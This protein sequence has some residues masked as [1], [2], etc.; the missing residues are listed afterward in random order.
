M[1]WSMSIRG[2]VLRRGVGGGSVGGGDE[3]FCEGL[4]MRKA[5]RGYR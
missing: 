4:V 2:G 5:L 3:V 1:R